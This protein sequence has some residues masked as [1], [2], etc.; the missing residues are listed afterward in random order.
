MKHTEGGV[1]GEPLARSQVLTT[2]D[3]VMRLEVQFIAQAGQF[4]QRRPGRPVPLVPP[5]EGPPVPPANVDEVLAAAVRIARTFIPGGTFDTATSREVL[6]VVLTAVREKER[7]DYVARLDEFAARHHDRLE[8]LFREYGP[9]SGFEVHGRYE[10][11][12]QPE[13]IVICERLD[14]AKFLLQAAWTDELPEQWLRDIAE[15]WV[16]HLAW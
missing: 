9:G 12:S 6:S 1:A 7:A 10:L 3:G 14:A 4:G 11:A 13:S 8:R 16:V 15:A 5:A 2:A